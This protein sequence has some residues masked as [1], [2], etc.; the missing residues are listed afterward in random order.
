MSTPVTSKEDA[1][2]PLNPADLDR[3][4]AI[5]S[6]HVGEPRGSFFRKRLAQAQLRPDDFVQIGVVR[7]GS[8]AGFAF[9]RI[10]RGEF[11]RQDAT[12]SL[13]AVGV[14]YDSRAR[15][16]GGALMRSLA[17]ALHERGVRALQSEADWTDHALLRFFDGSGFGL[18]PRLILERS[19]SAPLADPVTDA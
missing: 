5:D 2:R 8:L 11:G 12:A 15:G 18:A 19:V 4:I 10:E 16:V 13:D 14:E 17:A 7:E 1:I 3:V 6:S 9:A